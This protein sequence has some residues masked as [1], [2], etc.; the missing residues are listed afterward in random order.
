MKIEIS[1]EDYALLAQKIAPIIDMTKT[2]FQFDDGVLTIPD[3]VAGKVQALLGEKNWR[4][5]ATAN[6]LS[7]YAANVR[8]RKE[9][10]GI[11][12][13]DGIS[14]MT[15]R[16][17]QVMIS[18]AAA[19]ARADSTQ[20]FRWKTSNGQFI[21]LSAGQMTDLAKAVAVYIEKCF[22]VEA[23]LHAAIAAGSITTVEQVDAAF[24]Q[25]R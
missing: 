8:W 19:L 22:A 23:Q 10:A 21:Q 5:V 16:E 1:V 3:E 2:H 20:S 15:D 14:V 24:A 17:S 13:A 11:T 7:I 9:S 18:A 4:A 12:T 6:K 25:V